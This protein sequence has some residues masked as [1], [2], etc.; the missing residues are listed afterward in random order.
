MVWVFLVGEMGLVF[1]SV[2]SLITKRVHGKRGAVLG[3]VSSF[4][5]GGQMVGPLIGG[6]L[7]GI[8]HDLAFIGLASVIFAY[9]FVFV[10]AARKRLDEQEARANSERMTGG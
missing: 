8:H 6:F 9:F 7:Y 10:F 5:S 1:P 3:L 4:Q 2:N